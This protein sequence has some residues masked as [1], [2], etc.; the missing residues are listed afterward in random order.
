MRRIKEAYGGPIEPKSRSAA[1]RGFLRPYKPRR[2]MAL[3]KILEF[4]DHNRIE[5]IHSENGYS[6]MARLQLLADDFLDLNDCVLRN[7]LR[8]NHA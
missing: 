6:S 4:D 8:N 3:G 7:I 1:D 5:S 2:R